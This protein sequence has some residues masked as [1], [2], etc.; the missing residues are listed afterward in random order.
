[1]SDRIEPALSAEEWNHGGDALMWRDGAFVFLESDAGGMRN[2]RTRLGEDDLPRVIAL[3][4]A[5]LSDSDPRKITRGD[6]GAIRASLSQQH[7]DST[8][9]QYMTPET[10]TFA[11]VLAALESYLPPA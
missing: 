5:A 11:R 4:N 7:F 1:M 2:H 8:D 9:D 10:R 3:A 6:I